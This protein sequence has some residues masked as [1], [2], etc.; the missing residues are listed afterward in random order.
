MEAIFGLETFLDSNRLAK[1]RVSSLAKSG[2]SNSVEMAH[3]IVVICLCCGVQKK[4][5]E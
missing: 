5:G 2:Y 1:S 4:E 3:Q